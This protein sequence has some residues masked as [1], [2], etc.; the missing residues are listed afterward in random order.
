DIGS[1]AVRAVVLKKGRSAWSLVAA[2]EEMLP[3]NAIQAGVTLEPAIVSGAVTRLIDSLRVKKA[4]VA[5]A[6]SGHAVIVKRLWLPTLEEADLNDRILWEAQ[7]Y[8]PF[9]L[10]EC[11]LDYRVISTGTGKSKSGVDV[12]LVAAQKAQ[13]NERGL[14]VEH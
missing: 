10:N 12:L 7:Q 13:I 4:R 5:S 14:V 6:L 2:A 3:G 11:Q 1:S 9:D 8:I